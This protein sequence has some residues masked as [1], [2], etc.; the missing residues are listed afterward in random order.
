MAERLRLNYFVE[1]INILYEAVQLIVVG[2]LVRATNNW[3]F[4]VLAF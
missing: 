1:D 2:G 4:M 3:T